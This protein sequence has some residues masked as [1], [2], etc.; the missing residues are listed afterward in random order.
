MT[1]YGFLGFAMVF[2]NAG[3]IARLFLF[4]TGVIDLCPELTMQ[5]C[6][7]KSSD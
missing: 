1:P 3:F 5:S 4:V 2:S 7:R 6:Y